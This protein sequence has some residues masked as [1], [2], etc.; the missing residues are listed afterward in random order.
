MTED[1]IKQAHD[2][3]VDELNELLEFLTSYKEK[4]KNVPGAQKRATICCVTGSHEH[5]GYG[6]VTLHDCGIPC[7][8]DSYILSV[9]RRLKQLKQ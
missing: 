9:Q 6:S 8:I 7:L 4:Q 1:I 5:D 3:T 2:L